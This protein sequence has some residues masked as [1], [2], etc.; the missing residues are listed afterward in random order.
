MVKNN[1]IKFVSSSRDL[2]K[3]GLK[4]AS[5]ALL[6][7]AE[8]QDFTSGLNNNFNYEYK[9]FKQKKADKIRF[10][11]AQIKSAINILTKTVNLGKKEIAPSDIKYLKKLF[12]MLKDKIEKDDDFLKKFYDDYI[13]YAKAAKK[14][15]EANEIVKESLKKKK[16]NNEN[17]EEGQQNASQDGIGSEKDTD[18]GL[19][20]EDIQSW[21]ED[22]LNSAIITINK[23]A[24]LINSLEEGYTKKIILMGLDE[25]EK[26]KEIVTQEILRRQVEQ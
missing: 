24:N 17:T 11:F 25:I 18:E 21:S 14:L 16:Q 20:F 23:A 9:Y 26:A 2:D 19:G 8:D 22:Q 13:A 7:I 1:I 6:V 10:Y 3:I 15:L 5:E 12:S 4:I